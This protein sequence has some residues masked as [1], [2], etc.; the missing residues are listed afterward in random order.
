MPEQLLLFQN[1]SDP[2]LVAQIT[3]LREQCE[4]LRKGQFAKIGELNKRYIELQ[5][6]LE[7]LKNALCRCQS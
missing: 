4:R 7:I 6:E 5:Y 2:Y 3:A 1:D